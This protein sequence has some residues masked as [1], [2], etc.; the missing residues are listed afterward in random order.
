MTDDFIDHTKGTCCP[1]APEKGDLPT[2]LRHLIGSHSDTHGSEIAVVRANLHHQ[3]QGEW[4]RVFK[5]GNLEV[6]FVCQN[7]EKRTLLAQTLALS[8]LLPLVFGLSPKENEPDRFRV[9]IEV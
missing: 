5:K 7:L 2:Y 1:Y 8:D 9:V 3:V 4:Q 6:I